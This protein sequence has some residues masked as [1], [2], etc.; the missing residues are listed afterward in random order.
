MQ[1]GSIKEALTEIPTETASN[2]CKWTSINADP[3]TE[4]RCDIVW[5]GGITERWFHT[6]IVIT[7]TTVFSLLILVLGTQNRRRIK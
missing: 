1:G 3:D 2:D 5:G 7:M 6:G 4:M